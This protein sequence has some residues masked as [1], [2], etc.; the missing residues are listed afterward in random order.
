MRLIPCIALIALFLF[1][2]FA[3]NTLAATI[4]VPADHPTIQAGIDAAVDGD[5]VLVAPGTYAETIDFLGK[6]ITLRSEAGAD[7][8][9]VDGNY[10]GSVVTFDSGETEWTIIEGFTIQNGNAEIGGG[11]FCNSASPTIVDCTISDNFADFDG[12]AIYCRDAS[13]VITNCTVTR[14][15]AESIF[16][17]YGGG[18]F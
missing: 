5:L 18:I 2:F 12:G 1:P 8:T 15:S 3:P 10:T 9:V 14:N 4:H 13:P 17:G 16:P 7:L 6:G 11:L